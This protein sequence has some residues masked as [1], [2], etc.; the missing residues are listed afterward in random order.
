[1]RPRVV[2][3]I[4]ETGGMSSL[5]ESDEMEIGLDDRP[6]VLGGPE[7]IDTEWVVEK[8]GALEWTEETNDAQE[9]EWGACLVIYVLNAIGWT[10]LS[11]LSSLKNKSLINEVLIILFSNIRQ[12]IESVG[13]LL[14][15][16]DA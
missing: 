5:S 9:E 15:Q 6:E 16:T 3:T 11:A 13:N 10:Q 4:L 2:G 8:V 1:M 7:L 12:F 14:T